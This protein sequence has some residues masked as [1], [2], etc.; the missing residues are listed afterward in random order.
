MRRS[1]FGSYRIQINVHTAR[2]QAGF[3]SDFLCLEAT[4]PK[5]PR[6]QSCLLAIRAIG[7]AKAPMNRETADNRM[8]T[9]DGWHHLSSMHELTNT[10]QNVSFIHFRQCQ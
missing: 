6:A 1:H 4:F 10:S 7:S 9:N 3:V 2:Q 8:S 5:S